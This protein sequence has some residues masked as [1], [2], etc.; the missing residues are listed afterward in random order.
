MRLFKKTN[1][2]FVGKYKLAGIFSVVV[3]VI[4]LSSIV[5]KGGL[6]LSIDFTGGSIAQLK[7]ENPIDIKE[8]R[9]SLQDQGFTN[10]EIVTVGSENE[11]IIRTQLVGQDL[12]EKLN[13]A[14][15][16]KSFETR[17]IELVGPKIGKELSTTAVRAI[18]VALLLILIYIGFRFDFYYA[19]GSVVA[20][21]HDILFTVT[22][23]SLADLEINLAI[24]AAFLTIVGYSLNDTIV[25]FD[26]IRENI[27]IRAKESLESIVNCSLNET[28]SRTIITSLTTLIVVIFLNI[29]GSELIKLFA[30]ALIFGVIIGTYSSVFVASPTMI[31]FENRAGRKLKKKK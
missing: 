24:I 4:G 27:K 3:I 2:D 19:V 17:R 5:M 7:F 18:A 22:I 26:R 15:A 13:T 23:F 31:F 8:A 9:K 1:I 16:N 10:V 12:K 29:F 21:I 20:L 11:V 25:V 30:L 14:F 28:L 6:N